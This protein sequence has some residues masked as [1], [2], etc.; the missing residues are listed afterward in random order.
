[1]AAT[2]SLRFYLVLHYLVDLLE[3]P[4]PDHLGHDVELVGLDTVIQS[5]AVKSY[6]L[7]NAQIL[8]LLQRLLLFSVFVIVP[9]IERIG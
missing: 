9:G 8:L 6:L 2:E 5:T 4:E 3:G 7:I 1:M